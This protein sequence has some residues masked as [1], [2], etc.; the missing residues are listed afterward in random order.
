MTRIDFYI[1]QDQTS[2][3]SMRFACALGLK[4]YLKG[5]PVH[6]HVPDQ[7]YA[8]ELDGLMW[9]Y[10]KHR[11][12][13]HEILAESGKPSSPVQ[14]SHRPPHHEQGLLI[15]LGQDV[16]TFFGRFDRVAEIIVAET[17]D[18]GRTRYKHYRDRGYPLH[19]HEMTDWEA[20]A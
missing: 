1:L 4:A 6:I 19:H 17:R 11:F 18:L 9:D 16:P 15:N 8:E 5:S 14:I 2:D 12:I 20:S 3:A 10:P 13:P 7:A